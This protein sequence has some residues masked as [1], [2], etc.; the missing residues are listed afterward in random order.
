[1]AAK[2]LALIGGVCFWA[3][4]VLTVISWHSQQSHGTAGIEYAQLKSIDTK[5]CRHCFVDLKD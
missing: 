3:F 5:L 4:G 2:W 1:M